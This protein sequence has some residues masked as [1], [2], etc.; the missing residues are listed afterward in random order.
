MSEILREIRL[1]NT[2][3]VRFID[4]T[5]HYYGGFFHVSVLVVCEVGVIPEHCSAGLNYEETVMLLGP[6]ALFKKRLDRMG[7]P[8]E[9]IESMKTQLIDQFWEFSRG[10][11]SDSTFPCRLI[12]AEAIKLRKDKSRNPLR[13]SAE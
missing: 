10:Y 8:Q 3:L 12:S 13:F 9:E 4:Q 6:T 7:V 5:T 1:D 2:V 11:L